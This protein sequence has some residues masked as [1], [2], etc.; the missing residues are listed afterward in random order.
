MIVERKK[1]NKIDALFIGYDDQENIGL[2][3]I[4]AFLESY[5]FKSKLVPFGHQDVEEVIRLAKT[6]SPMLIGFSIIFQYTVEKFSSL[7]SAMREAGIDVHFTV[8][9]H[10]PSMRPVEFLN[11]MKQ[12]DSVVCFEGELTALE[13]LQK[14][15]KPNTWS[16]ILGLTYRINSEVITNP[17][18]PLI[19][20]L[21]SLPLP[22]R[23]KFRST[24]QGVR[25]ANILSS[26]GCYHNCSFCS[27]RQFY[28]TP[29][30]PLRRSRSP[31][32]VAS[33]MRDLYET[34]GVKFFIF[35]DDD[36][37]ARSKKQRQWIESFLDG[38]KKHRLRGKI[39]WRIGCRVDDVDEK[40]FLRCR[41]YGLI[42]VFMGVESGNNEGL[43]T[44]NKK[45]TVEDNLAAIETLKRINLPFEIG[46]ML[47]DPESTIETVGENIKFLRK[48]ASDGSCSIPFSKMLPYAGTPAEKKL[49]EQGRLK[50][51]IG[52]PDYDFLDIRLNFYAQFVSQ[53]FRFRN[54]DDLGLVERLRAT[55]VVN[56]LMPL[57]GDSNNC[58]KFQK[59]LKEICAKTNIVA[60]NTLESA[61][62]FIAKRDFIGIVNDWGILDYLA[63]IEHNAE[64]S[65]RRELDRALKKFNP[66]MLSVY[67]EEYARRSLLKNSELGSKASRF[68]SNSFM[69]ENSIIT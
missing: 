5:G 56:N 4:M 10:F 8:G 59:S 13:L 1:Q 29:P 51:T 34:S 68:S 69:L 14:I 48:I 19:S 55:K 38:L 31:E 53:V 44:L 58:E 33:E 46:F 22:K 27:I 30:G 12:F 49:I 24:P 50:G 62:K 60:L 11:T 63:S 25:I 9:G 3:S 6:H 45:I 67:K 35:Q 28:G 52:N 43:K 37:A 36:F 64:E 16:S 7:A 32:S 66:T 20:D 39:A 18:R 23:T 57:F 26:R 2:R 15:H 61:L 47:F 54:F 40:L 21:D 17:P 41:D 42:A 65:L